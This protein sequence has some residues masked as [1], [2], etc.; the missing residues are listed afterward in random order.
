MESYN[1]IIIGIHNTNISTAKNF[2]ISTDELRLI[3]RLSQEKKVI[4][5]LFSSPYGINLISSTDDIHAIVLAHQDSRI[6]N[7]IAAQQIMGAI[8][9]RGHLPVGI[10]HDFP[11]H[12]GITTQAI[13]RLQYSIPEET[14]IKREDLKAIDSIV[15]YNIKEKAIPGCQILIAKNGKVIYQKSF[16]YHTYRKGRFVKNTDLY[17]LASIT[18]I[19]AT[20][21]SVMRL[22]DERKLDIDRRL[23][24]YLPYLQGTN[25]DNIIIRDMMTHHAKLK[26]WI[27]F[28]LNTMKNNKLD[29]QW[30]SNKI[31]EQ[32]TVK[33]ASN[34]Y[35]NKNYSFIIYD[36]IV[37]SGLRNK[38]NYKYSDLGFY[39]LKQ[40]IEN[41][42]NKPLELYVS[43]TFYQPLGLQYTVYNPLNSFSLKNIVPTEDDDY[44]R[45]QLIHGYVHDPG[46]AM[47]GG[48]SGHAGLFANSNDMAI[49]MQMLLQKGL[50]GGIQYLSPSTIK[51]FTKQQFPL[52]DNRRGIGF[53][54]PEP[55]NRENG[56][57]CKDASLESFGHSG[58]TGTYMW[59]D[60][61]YQLV[62]IFLSNRIHP[63]ALNTKLI[64]MNTRTKIQQ[65]IYDAIPPSEK[66]LPEVM[67][68]RADNKE[69]WK[70]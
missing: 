56:P 27:P 60:P 59:A 39:L 67:E 70:N 65:I 15:L 46:A 69:L 1:L 25:K 47:L 29:K 11:L 28:Y 62:Y 36:S 66:G 63:T 8:G 14:G 7:K 16:G 53:D 32:F 37:K 35:I 58:F 64:K 42:T 49:L 2:G 50:Y 44:F 18:K 61:E 4:L 52:N 34:L 31:T 26:P 57:T 48:I 41:L 13:A 55:E 6:S 68:I 22:Y 21:L 33:V 51:Q 5:G 3:K 40:T 17:D 45:H 20:T 43:E 12:W 10:S 9:F 30:Y 54:K 19:A 24:W 23:M 38:R